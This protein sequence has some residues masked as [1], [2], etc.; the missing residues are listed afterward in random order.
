[1]LSHQPEKRPTTFGI[2]S[3]PP[4]NQAG[5][6]LGPTTT[7][8]PQEWHF[9]LPLFR[10]RSLSSSGSRSSSLENGWEVIGTHHNEQT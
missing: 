1:M 10:S 9:E 7:P 3:M 5:I 2:R 6:D 4:I 8:I